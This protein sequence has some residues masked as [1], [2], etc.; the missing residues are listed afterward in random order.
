MSFL[1]LKLPGRRLPWPGPGVPGVEPGHEVPIASMLKT[2]RSRH[3]ATLMGA[4]MFAGLLTLCSLPAAAAQ[5]ATRR[6]PASHSGQPDQPTLVVKAP[7]NGK[8]YTVV[9]GT[10]VI[11][12]LHRKGW[13]FTEPS[14]N[15]P[16]VLQQ[17]SSSDN[18]GTGHGT[19]S[20]LAPGSATI[21]ATA[22][23]RCSKSG[24][25]SDLI[26]V[27]SVNITVSGSGS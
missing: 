16:T 21:S 22:R 12:V 15:A 10:T 2:Q 11:V 26:M 1:S 17:T 23:P 18:H 4:L 14:S 9:S 19:F 25:C 3:A 24:V 6:G 8:S 20:A 5:P 7:A 27:W 13:T